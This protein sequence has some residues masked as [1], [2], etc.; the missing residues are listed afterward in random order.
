MQSQTSDTDDSSCGHGVRH[1]QE[2]KELCQVH[3]LPA[4][5]KLR[6]VSLQ[7]FAL[8]FVML[9]FKKP[10]RSLHTTTDKLLRY[11]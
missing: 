7:Y 5:S 10:T 3:N 4:G 2:L 6:K 8:L 1:G 9:P 11:A